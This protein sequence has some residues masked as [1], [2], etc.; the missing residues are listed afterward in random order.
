MSKTATDLRA[1]AAQDFK[2]V[3]DSFDRCD[4]DGFLSQWASD[5]NGR[6]KLAQA[7]I[8]EHGGKALFAQDYLIN[9]ATGE[10][11][12]DAR[13]CRTRYG[14]K[15]RIDSTDEWLPYNPTRESTLAKKGYREEVR[16]EVCEA[17]AKSWCPTNGSYTSVQ[18]RTFRSDMSDSQQRYLGWRHIGTP[19]QEEA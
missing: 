2:D 10:E 14:L 11:V 3:E 13:L 19:D 5:I 12:T 9:R 8:A 6:V 1:E 7:T 15:W 16:Y 4:T 17:R 18:V